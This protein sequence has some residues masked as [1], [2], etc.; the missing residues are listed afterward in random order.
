M[1]H[2]DKQNDFISEQLLVFLRNKEKEQ[3]SL[4]KEEVW[5]RII[6]QR[7]QAKI[8]QISIW[9]TVAAILSGVL[10]WLPTLKEPD[11][12][13]MDYM[14]NLQQD[15]INVSDHV[16]LITSSGASIPLKKESKNL[17]YDHKGLIYI[18]S[19]RLKTGETANNTIKETNKDAKATNYN[20]L[21]VP[22]G[23][24]IRLTL[25]DGSVLDVN[26]GSKVVYPTTFSNEKREIFVD[27]EIFIDVKSTEKKVPFIV[28]TSRCDVHVLGTAFNVRN[29]D[30]DPNTEVVLQRGIVEV[31]DKAQHVIRMKPNERTVLLAGHY[32]DKHRVD[33]SKYILWREGILLFE[34]ET[35]N[36]AT[37][38][39][40]H[41]YGKPF[42]CSPEVQDIR[43]FGKL[44]IN[45]PLEEVL[46]GISS[47]AGLR[48]EK[49]GDGY[50]FMKTP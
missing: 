4:P 35:V 48:C 1:K 9:S 15:K 26:S 25:S 7:R 5:Q 30:S 19:E 46:A 13:I 34:G 32:K 45:E 11:T 40:H 3:H 22:L 50:I 37:Q 18:D 20:H 49:K 10:F 16:Q 31:A 47:A 42:Y 23:K 28:H 41:F 6:R 33:V 44:D 36:I 21:L 8:R 29:Y 43:L 39:L 2:T 12:G 38:K 17:A 24:H 14:A 27:G